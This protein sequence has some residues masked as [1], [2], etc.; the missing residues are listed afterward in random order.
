MFMT[1]VKNAMS[2]YWKTY[3]PL[4]KMTKGHRI[5]FCQ[6]LRSVVYLI[7]LKLLMA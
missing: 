1:A 4:E 3:F 7:I 6:I 2:S 5:E